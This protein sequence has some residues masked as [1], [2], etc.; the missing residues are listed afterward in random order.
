VKSPTLYAIGFGSNLGDRL[1]NLERGLSHMENKG[2]EILSTSRIFRSDALGMGDAPEFLNMAAIIQTELDPTELISLLHGIEADF[3]RERSGLLPM[4]RNLDLDILLW[5]GGTHRQP[6][7][8][9]PRMARRLFVL[10]PLAE[11]AGEWRHPERDLTIA[12]LLPHCEDKSRCEP[13]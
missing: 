7:I 13:L 10:L 5:A 2:I 1:E 3:G 6:D 11:I 9:H 8:P 4:S 12:Q